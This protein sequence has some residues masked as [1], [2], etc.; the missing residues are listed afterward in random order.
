M[1]ILSYLKNLTFGNGPKSEARVLI[2][3][4][5]NAGKSSILRKMADEDIMTVRPTMGFQ[6][7]VLHHGDLTLNVWDVGGIFI[8]SIL[9]SVTCFDH[10]RFIFL[11]RAAKHS[12]VLEKLF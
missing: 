10:F 7:K 11:C 4:L 5:D 12:S 6:I 9:T 8:V 2:L 1:G 3:G